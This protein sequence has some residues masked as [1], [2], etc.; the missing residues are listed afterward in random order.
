MAFN[1]IH[2]GSKVIYRSKGA[3]PVKQFGF[4]EFG[5][6]SPYANRFHAP[7]GFCAFPSVLLQQLT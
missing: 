1:F 4:P 2:N 5:K 3:M 7:V 6:K